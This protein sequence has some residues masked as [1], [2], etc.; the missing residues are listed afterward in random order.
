MGMVSILLALIFSAVLCF[1][2][3]PK[4]I[5]NKLYKEFAL[6]SVILCYGLVIAVMKVSIWISLIGRADCP[7]I[8][9]YYRLHERCFGISE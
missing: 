5:Q 6:F 9:A 1:I 2:E 4:M 8:C 7:D 3:I